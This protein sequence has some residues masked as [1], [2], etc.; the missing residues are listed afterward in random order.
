[1]KQY[2]IRGQDDAENPETGTGVGLGEQLP[3]DQIGTL[4]EPSDNSNLPYIIE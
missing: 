1:L 3:K 2:E 4:A